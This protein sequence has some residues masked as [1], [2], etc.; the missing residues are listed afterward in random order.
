MKLLL[1]ENLSR[2]LVPFLQEAYPGTSQV[3]MLGLERADDAAIWVYAKANDYVIVSQDADFHER[4]LVQGAPP[5]L[6]W[7]KL[8]NPSKAQVLQALLSRR[9]HIE[10]HLLREGKHTVELLP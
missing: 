3:A 7:L 10:Q 4:A 9:E 2:R 6:I 8:Y 1:D 5:F